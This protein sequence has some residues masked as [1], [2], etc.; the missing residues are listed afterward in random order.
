MLKEEEFFADWLARVYMMPEGMIGRK[1][2]ADIYRKRE[3]H[4]ALYTFI[5]FWLENGIR[6]C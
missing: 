1:Q 6:M 2:R 4:L 3:V 5:K